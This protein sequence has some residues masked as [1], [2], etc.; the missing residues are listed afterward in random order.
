RRR[1][2]GDGRRQRDP[3]RG[4]PQASREVQVHRARI[5]RGAEGDRRKRDA[6][7]RDD[8]DRLR[9]DARRAPR[10]PATVARLPGRDRRPLLLPLLDLQAVRYGARRPRGRTARV[11]AAHRAV[12]DLPRQRRTREDVGAHAE[13]GRVPRTRLRGRRLR[14]ADRGRGDAEGGRAY[15][16]RPRVAARGAALA[17]LPRRVPTGRAAGSAHRLEGCTRSRPTSAGDVQPVSCSAPRISAWS[18]SRTRRA[19]ASPSTVSPQSGG[20]PTS[21]AAAPSASAFTTSVPL[22]TP[23]STSTST[24]PSTASTTSGSASIVAE[25]PSS[26]LPPWFETTI[27]AAPCS[28]A[29]RASS[30]VNS[31]FTTS[32][33]PAS[34]AIHSRSRH[35]TDGEM[36]AATSTADRPPRPSDAIG[37]SSGTVNA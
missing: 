18:S 32:G 10:A 4:L 13:R 3:H 9:R 6:H 35:V 17:G 11:L 33:T 20:R 12:A 28:H 5:P 1:A 23:P 7:D 16:P 24:R 21:T 22:R 8:G 27:A 36:S 14:L 34:A 26:C 19:P 30:A 37:T 31:P 25:T 2:L 29:S 15:R